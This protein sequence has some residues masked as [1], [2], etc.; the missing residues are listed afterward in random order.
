VLERLEDR[1]LLAGGFTEVNLASD[2]P[3]LARIT[4]PN[5]V[6]PWGTSFSPTGPFWFADNGSAV[7]D[8]LNGRGQPLALVVS[9]PSGTPSGTVFNGGTGFVISANGLSAP[10][11]FLFATE[12]GTISGWSDLIDPT[13]ALVAVDNSSSGSDYKGL[14]LA[15]TGGHGYLYA[16][17]FSHGTIDV[18]DQNFRPVVRPGAFQDPNLPSGFAPFNI[19]N[20]NN[21]L[22]VTYARQNEAGY[23]DVAGAGNGF[24]D[25]YAPDGS[26]VKRLAS[27]GDLNSPWGL[28]LAPADFGPFGG[29]LLVANH[30]DGHITAYD[31]G[32][33]ALL[34]QLADASGTP[35]AI[36]N[37]WALTF[38][39][40][41]VGGDSDTL[42]FTAGVDNEAHGLFGAIQTSAR[43]GAD[44]AGSLPFDPTAPGETGDYPLPPTNGPAFQANIVERPV[45]VSDLLPLREASLVVVPTLSSFPPS[46][47][48]PRTS[49]STA[50]PADVSLNGPFSSADSVTNAIILLSAEASSQ[51]ASDAPSNA[52]LNA[53][54]DWNA[55]PIAYPSG[56]E[57]EHPG[58]N[59][60]SVGE[61]LLSRT[62]AQLRQAQSIQEQGPGTLSPLNRATPSES[63]AGSA[64]DCTESNESTEPLNGKWTNL[65]HRFL[66][67][68]L[69]VIWACWL[70]YEVRSRQ[71]SGG[72]EEPTPAGRS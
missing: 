34:G 4:D 66:I 40:G 35:L 72:T 17:D 20:V 18:F 56:S 37:L 57:R 69:P 3:G 28:T 1:C 38:G 64:D 16:A 39:N 6:D 68:T 47:T 29:A 33:G 7:S 52:S 59:P 22:F 51:P 21:R 14:A 63:R 54:L 61:D 46:S 9:I 50:A 30:G 45:S 12:A 5:L 58:S 49:G 53:L 31:P 43:R 15:Y 13:R 8:L 10:S 25:V 36:P 42:F 67:V 60:R 24:V 48:S 2:V 62:Y 55:S 70:R 65:M 71:A 41:H 32:S 23:D 44:T 19:Q 27:Q 11:R 26:L